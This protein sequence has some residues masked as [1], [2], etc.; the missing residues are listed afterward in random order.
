MRSKIQLFVP[1]AMIAVSGLLAGCGSGSGHDMGSMATP[2]SS[3]PATS[4]SVTSAAG[5]RNNADVMFTTGMIP[6]HLQAVEM[7]DVLLAKDE[8]DP[9]VR[10]LA[11]RIKAS[12]APEIAQMRGWLAGWGQ[13]P[14]PS[15]GRDHAGHGGD[16]SGMMSQADMD[17][18]K[19]A[20]GPQA[21]KLFLTGMIKHHQGAV[22]M[23]ET[24][25]VEGQN[26]AAKALAQ[27]IITAQNAEITE[28]TTLLDG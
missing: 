28:M 3:A 22:A 7:S 9:K 17:A 13:N 4:S 26:P 12:Q 25:L 15:T 24:E 1:A 14:S 23:A 18:L 10:D 8:V 11:S 5:A 21:T 20:A 19:R 6:H 27:E 2:A 16:D